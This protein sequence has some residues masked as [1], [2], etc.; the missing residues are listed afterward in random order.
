MRARFRRRPRASDQRRPSVKG[1]GG[2]RRRV[3]VG[4]GSWRARSGRPCDRWRARFRPRPIR[5]AR[6][7]AFS[8]PPPPRARWS[9]RTRTRAQKPE[10]RSASKETLSSVRFGP[11]RLGPETT[12]SARSSPRLRLRSRRARTAPRTR[13]AERPQAW[14]PSCPTLPHPRN[15]SRVM[16]SPTTPRDS[17]SAPAASRS[18]S[19]RPGF[20]GGDVA[21]ATQ[22]GHVSSWCGNRPDGRMRIGEPDR[23][24]A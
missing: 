24:F 5:P 3:A 15:L 7:T 19:P 17:S 21:A 20:S 4:G 11:P 14:H 16:G 18:G 10:V 9:V 2:P 22:S 13:P 6:R 23:R 8:R 12:I 1:L